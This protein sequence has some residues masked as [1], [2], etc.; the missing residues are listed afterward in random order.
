MIILMAKNFGFVP[1]TIVLSVMTFLAAGASGYLFFVNQNSCKFDDKDLCQF[2]DRGNQTNE[3]IKHGY[4]VKST[5]IDQDEK[6]TE[7][8]WE[9]ESTNRIHIVNNNDGEET[10]NMMIIDNDLYVKDYIDDYWWKKPVA[11]EKTIGNEEINIDN[12]VKTKQAEFKN[13][14][15]LQYQKIGKENCDNDYCFKYLVIDP[16]KSEKQYLYFSSQDYLL[17]KLRTENNNGSISEFVISYKTLLVQEP[18]LVKEADLD[19]NIFGAQ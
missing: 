11:T 17:R 1:V 4:T 10:L 5:T 13:L 7:T 3:Y 2:L 15:D 19:Q 8:L 14:N 12:I 6:K 16:S 9:N 18:T